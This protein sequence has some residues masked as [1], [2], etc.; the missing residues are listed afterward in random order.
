MI[1]R[2]NTAL[3]HEWCVMNGGFNFLVQ[4]TVQIPSSKNIM[5]YDNLH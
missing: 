5:V 1:L 4:N 3:Y 2:F